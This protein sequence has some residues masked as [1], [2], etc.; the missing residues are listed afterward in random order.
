MADYRLSEAADSDLEDI[1]Y[2]GAVQFGQAQSLRYL[3]GLRITFERIAAN[4]HA[5]QAVNDIRSGYRRAVYR[6]HAIY[7]RIEQ[8][9][10]LVVRVLGQQNPGAAL[11]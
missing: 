1:L 3:E 8:E 9:G 4:P 11:P 2:F 10:I 7:Y 5:Y 6:S